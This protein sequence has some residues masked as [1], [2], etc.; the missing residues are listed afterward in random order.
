[1]KKQRRNEKRMHAPCLDTMFFYMMF[2]YDEIEGTLCVDQVT[3]AL[4]FVN[5]TSGHVICCISQR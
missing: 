5:R 2:F 3:A 4:G 1:M